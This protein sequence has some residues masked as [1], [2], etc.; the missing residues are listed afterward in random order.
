MGDFHA[1]STAPGRRGKSKPDRWKHKTRLPKRSRGEEHFKPGFR[2]TR[3]TDRS[4][5]LWGRWVIWVDFGQDRLLGIH[6]SMV[7]P[8]TLWDSIPGYTTQ[9]VP[10]PIS[11][12]LFREHEANEELRMINFWDAAAGFRGR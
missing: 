12:Q 10:L 4:D 3:T 5:P 2:L 11:Q 6:C 9:H 7:R 8:T 1:D